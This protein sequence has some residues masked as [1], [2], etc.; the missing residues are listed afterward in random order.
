MELKQ[1][2]FFSYSKLQCFV[3]QPTFFAVAFAS[4]PPLIYSKSSCHKYPVAFASLHVSLNHTFVVLL[5]SEVKKRV[6]KKH[7]N[8]GIE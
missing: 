6:G 7:Q 4:L 5:Q 2:K 8:K 3:L 1:L